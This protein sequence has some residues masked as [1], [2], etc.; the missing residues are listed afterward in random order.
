M[1]AAH[2][3]GARVRSAW[4]W[5]W[6]SRALEAARRAAA[7]TAPV[8][9]LW[10]RSRLAAELAERT[11]EPDVPL[12]DGP[13]HALALSLYRE[14]AYWALSARQPSGAS[15]ARSL[16]ELLSAEAQ[17]AR[18]TGLSDSE[19]ARVRVVLAE[20]TFVDWAETEH[21]RRIADAE[22]TR[23]F[24]NALLEERG[25]A[26]E[27]GRAIARV[28]SQRAFRTLA[29][30][31]L[32]AAL[33]ICGSLAIVRSLRGP[34]LALGKPWS[35]SKK[36][37][38]C[39]PEWRK[40]GD[41]RTRIF[42]HTKHQK[43]PWF[44]LDL[45]SETTVGRVE[46]ENRD[47]CCQ[48]RALPLVVEVSDDKQAFREVAR[49]TTPFDTWHATFPPLHARFVRLR[50]DGRNYLHLSRVSVRRN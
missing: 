39:H 29:V 27:P 41:A 6:R 35:V 14:A 36:W 16:E 32:L 34:D 37:A 21:S 26:R 50:V 5:I 23:R 10:R 48:E 18:V 49:R 25:T 22:L 45:G 9:E 46:V 31:L 20:Q 33:A 30:L 38:D 17:G 2:D 42:F 1:F 47:D 11:L 12:A 13:G 24:V 43:Q 7:E 19:L 4:E 3:S 44:L 40:C 8:R 15:E 28:Y